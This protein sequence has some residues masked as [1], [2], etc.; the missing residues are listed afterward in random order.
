[1]LLELVPVPAVHI[2]DGVKLLAKL[3]LIYGQGGAQLVQRRAA[4]A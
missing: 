4:V 3:L 1:M 2:A